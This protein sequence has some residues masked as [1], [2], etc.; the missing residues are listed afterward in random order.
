[1]S[2]VLGPALCSGSMLASQRI[3][4]S[5][6]TRALAIA[7]AACAHRW[8]WGRAH[9]ALESLSRPAQLG[10][11][12]VFMECHRQLP[13]ALES[14]RRGM[15]HSDPLSEAILGHIEL[16]GIP[17]DLF[18]ADAAAGLHWTLASAR[19]GLPY[20]EYQLGLDLWRGAGA[21]RDEARATHW[22]K[23]A[24]AAGS[25]EAQRWLAKHERHPPSLTR[26]AAAAPMPTRSSTRTAAAAATLV[27]SS[28]AVA[29]QK[30]AAPL[31]D[32][33]RVAQ[34]LQ[35]FWTL[36][37]RA[38]NAKVVDF[39]TPALVRPVGFGE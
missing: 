5:Q 38:S 31:A 21:Q 8:S 26:V 17:A 14:A 23:R 22:M 27:Q 30:S 12:A 4:V 25:E 35:S 13:H 34:S 18:A 20:G 32:G 33:Q 9:M 16:Q 24:A 7:R 10:G 3:R 29:P 19:Q 28:A 36:Y 6:D 15:R 37:F 39:G 1:M 11:W 2:G